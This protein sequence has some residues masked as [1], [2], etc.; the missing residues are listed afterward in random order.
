MTRAALAS[1]LAVLAAG[2]AAA[3]SHEEVTVSHGYSNFGELKY[4]PGE[5]FDYVNLDAPKGGE[6]SLWSQGNFDSFNPYTRK[7]VPV[8]G[9]DLLYEDLMI[10]AA[11][12]PYGAY[13]NLCVTVEYPESLDW[14]VMTLRD[15]VR[16]ADGTPMTAHDVK[17]TIDLFLEQGITEF[18]NVIDGWF[19]SVEVIDDH[20]I[21]FEFTEEASK[22]DRMGI[23]G[24]WNPF[25]KDWFER[26][27][28]RID[29]ST[30]EPFMGTGP[31][32]GGRRRHRPLGRLRE[33]PRLVGGGSADQPRP[34]Q[35]RRGA[36]RV[37][38]RRLGRARG[39]Q[40]GRVHV[41]PGEHL[42]P[43][44][45]RL[46]LPGR[47]R[48]GTSCSR[49]SPTARPRPRRASCSTCA[50]SRGRTRACARPCA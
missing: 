36:L 16:F 28:A 9:T 34:L 49:R 45:D 20:T 6:I 35:L 4:G 2:H 32:V 46:R 47:A 38:R 42:A 44:G 1:I 10:A 37:L 25:S 13:C 12:D 27:G 5:P 15:D 26:T 21:R 22:R 41:P 24:L 31:Y 50:A 7:G 33:E 3:E 8:T 14:V 23:A 39:L 43:V 40:G 30:D 19:E 29:E 17:F 48:G 11:D 18:R